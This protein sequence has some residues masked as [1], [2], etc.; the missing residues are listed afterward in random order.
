MAFESFVVQID[1]KQ[2]QALM[3]ADIQTQAILPELMHIRLIA[4]SP[5]A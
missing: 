5:P 2:A 4:H 1:S 3:S